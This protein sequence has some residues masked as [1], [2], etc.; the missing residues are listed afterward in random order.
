MTTEDTIEKKAQGSLAYV[1]VLLFARERTWLRANVS[2]MQ[3]DLL[4]KSHLVLF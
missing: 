1:T 3:K 4:S 2:L